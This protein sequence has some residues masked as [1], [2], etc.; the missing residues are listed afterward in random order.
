MMAYHPKASNRKALTIFAL[1]AALLGVVI[2]AGA[3]LPG[4]AISTGDPIWRARN[5]FFTSLPIIS[6]IFR[7]KESLIRENEELKR[8]LAGEDALESSYRLLQAENVKLRSLMGGSA[9]SDRRLAAVLAR[10]PV[11]PYDIIVVDAGEKEGVKVGTL[12]FA[13]P[14]IALGKVAWVGKDESKVVLF[15]SSG[16]TLDVLVGTSSV[17]MQ[18]R[19]RGGQNF[20]GELPRGVDI[21]KGDPVYMPLGHSTLV[22]VV[23]EVARSEH[24]PFQTIYFESPVNVNYLRWVWLE[25]AQ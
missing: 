1:V 18:A 3:L 7:S 19:G 17:A 5:N 13:D 21:E 24:D 2:A 9:E 15:S 10:P 14:D 25:T 16:E 20:V 23:G 4:P 22:G 11:S 8:K 12:V 6:G